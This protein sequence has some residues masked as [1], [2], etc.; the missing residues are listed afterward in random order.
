MPFGCRISLR[1]I[2]NRLFRVPRRSKARKL[3]WLRGRAAI[4]RTEGTLGIMVGRAETS[5]LLSASVY[6]KASAA[7]NREWLRSDAISQV[8]A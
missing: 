7:G 4:F 2:P 5:W 3:S 1:H 8:S 6:I